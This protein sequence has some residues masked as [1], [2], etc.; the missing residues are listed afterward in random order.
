M[1]GADGGVAVAGGA[2]RHAQRLADPVGVSR[3]RAAQALVAADACSR[4]QPSH[5]QKW[6][7]VAKRDRSAPTSAATVR[8]VSTPTV[9]IAVKSA[10]SIRCSRSRTTLSRARR[11]GDGSFAAPSGACPSSSPSM[12]ASHASIWPCSRSWRANACLQ[13]GTGVRRASC[14]AGWPRWWSRPPCN[15]RPGTRQ[16]RPVPLARDDGA[17]D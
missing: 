10:P 3:R 17:H 5:G 1:R 16:R 15:D 13:G 7:A 8:A 4:R 11:P 2:R 12:R 6:P 14:P 9:G